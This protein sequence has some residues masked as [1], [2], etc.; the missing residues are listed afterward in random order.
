MVVHGRV[1]CKCEEREVYSRKK[2]NQFIYVSYISTSIS[3]TLAVTPTP[4]HPSPLPLRRDRQLRSRAVWSSCDWHPPLP[5]PHQDA[6]H[7]TWGARVE[8]ALKVGHGNCLDK[9]VYQCSVVFKFLPLSPHKANPEEL[10]HAVGAEL[11]CFLTYFPALVHT[12]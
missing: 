10:P 1:L 11:L 12:C 3:I 2:K 6:S 9:K 5:P 8:L 7:T 4:P